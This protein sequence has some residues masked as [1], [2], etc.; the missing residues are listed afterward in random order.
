M[1]KILDIERA[2]HAKGNYRGDIHY[3]EYYWV[4]H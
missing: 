4:A 3:A 1:K 2:F